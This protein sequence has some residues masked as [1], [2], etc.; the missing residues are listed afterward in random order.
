MQVIQ[1][2]EVLNGIKVLIRT[3]N[4]SVKMTP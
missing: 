1:Y 2:D 4:M 3:S